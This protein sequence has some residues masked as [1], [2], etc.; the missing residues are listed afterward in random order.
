MD[1]IDTL[2]NTA[3][4]FL[5]QLRDGDAI[6]NVE[7]SNTIDVEPRPTTPPP[8][9]APALVFLGTVLFAILITSLVFG[10]TLR[11]WYPASRT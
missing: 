6:D 5:V 9:L 11:K 2:H 8:Q 10:F 7:V 1:I 4:Y 3:N